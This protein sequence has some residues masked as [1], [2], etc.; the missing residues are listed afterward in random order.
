MLALI[1]FLACE[2]DDICIEEGT[3]SLVIR[4]FDAEDRTEFKP[5]PGL[6]IIGIGTNS[7][8]NTISDRTSTLDSINLPL[9]IDDI[10][11]GYNFI[12][13]SADDVDDTTIDTGNS[14]IINFNY[15]VRE[16]FIN[17]ACGFVAN[18]DELNTDFA[19]DPE[20]WIQSIE[21]ENTLI[22]NETIITAHVKIFH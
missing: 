9:R 17:R 3:P 8:V 21:I 13:N 2:K 20:N 15:I 18:F 14:D 6:R 5:V 10:T 7:T 16:R 19:A 11:T 12:T 4:F 22:E 1:S